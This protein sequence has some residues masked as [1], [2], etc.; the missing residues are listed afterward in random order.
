[1]EENI[2]G[3]DHNNDAGQI[4]FQHKTEGKHRLSYDTIFKG[5]KSEISD[6][7]EE[8]ITETNSE[9]FELD[10]STMVYEEYRDTERYLREKKVKEKVYQV[11]AE[12]TDINFLNN[13]RKPSKMDF[14]NYYVIVH[15]SLR[16]ERFSH[17]EL[18]NELSQ[19]FSDNLFNMF[20]LLDNKWRMGIIEELQEH[21]G[22]DTTKKVL[23]VKNLNEGTE[24]EFSVT[25]ITGVSKYITGIII[26]KD[27]DKKEYTVN[28]FENVYVIGYSDINKILNNRHKYNLNMLNN[29]DF[30]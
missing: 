24:I 25:D 6:F 9:G 20:K 29:I 1:M 16:D 15:T 28:S 18:F 3:E 17:V 26:T 21:V 2:N 30:L 19:Y 13:R 4:L 22:N 27:S 8:Y 11:L 7:D 10:Q 5:K 23:S 14:N 12:R